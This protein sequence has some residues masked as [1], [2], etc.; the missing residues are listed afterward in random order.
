VVGKQV[1]GL[2]EEG[3]S[4]SGEPKGLMNLQDTHW[5]A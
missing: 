3:V 1:T 4:A 5:I 2:K